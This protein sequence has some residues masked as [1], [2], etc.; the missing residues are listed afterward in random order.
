MKVRQHNEWFRT[1]CLKYVKG[2]KYREPELIEEILSRPDNTLTRERLEQGYETIIDIVSSRKSCP[3]CKAKLPPNEFV[4]SWGEYH[5]AKWRTVK[6]F[7]RQC[8]PTEV[9]QPLLSHGSDCGCQINLISKSDIEPDWITLS[10]KLPSDN[11]T[12]QLIH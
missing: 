3:C 9:Q 1:V 2:I 4:W 11:S 5:N 8:F 12:A 10:C 7:C 6:H